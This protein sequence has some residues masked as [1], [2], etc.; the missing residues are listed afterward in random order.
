MILHDH[1]ALE[2]NIL[3]WMLQCTKTRS[4]RMDNINVISQKWHVLIFNFRS[5][6]DCLCFIRYLTLCFCMDSNDFTEFHL[7][8]RYH[9]NIK[10]QQI[11]YASPNLLL[12]LLQNCCVCGRMCTL[13][14]ILALCS[15]NSRQHQTRY[16]CYPFYQSSI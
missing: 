5:L 10:K 8:F 13:V 7:L 2:C 16:T 15:C 12:P 3:M 6:I 14:N 1:V 11:F 4:L 9:A